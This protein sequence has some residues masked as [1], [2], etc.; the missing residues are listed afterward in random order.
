MNDSVQ[1]PLKFYACYLSGFS[2]PFYAELTRS[3]IDF[4]NHITLYFTNQM[5]TSP[6]KSYPYGI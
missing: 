1:L 5:N 6:T 2:G 3:I 4:L